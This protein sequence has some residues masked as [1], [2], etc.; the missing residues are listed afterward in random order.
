M[1]CKERARTGMRHDKEPGPHLANDALAANILA[2][3]PPASSA[4]HTA[5][6]SSLRRTHSCKQRNMAPAKFMRLH[7]D[8][9]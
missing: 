3:V 6:M 9:Q 4:S 5:R 2:A 8:V 7:D 1:H